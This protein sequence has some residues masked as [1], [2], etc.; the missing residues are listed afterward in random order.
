MSR[1]ALSL[2]L[3]LTVSLG[4]LAV[5]ALVVADPRELAARIASLDAAAFVGA[6]ALTA[7][8]R[9]LMAFKWR[10]LLL[11]RHVRIPL[12]TAVRAYF[13]SS[14]AGLFLPVTLGA[15]AARVAAT[16]QFGIA[17]VTAS[18]VVERTVGAA[19]V[20]LVAIGGCALIAGRL[21]A[22]PLASLLWPLG[23]AGVVVAIA[24][25]VSLWLSSRWAAQG[26]D[27]G[28]WLRR[29]AGAYGAYAAHPAT[30]TVF[31]LLSIVES[32]VPA[33]T[34]FVVARGLGIQA[35]AWLFLAAV[36][37]A[38]MV[39][40]LPVSLGGFGVQEAA[41][42]YLAGSLGLAAED[43]IATML[44]CDAILLLILLP[45]AFDVSILGQHRQARASEPGEA[46]R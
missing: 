8:D 32:L 41:F 3:R 1:R 2:A 38:L 45:A 43:A 5:L 9:V 46:G 16:R 22:V 12:T 35:P 28:T 6:I 27:R 7:G 24:F 34:A 29:V 23:I 42:V 21:A 39:A 11:A 20:I 31:F 30:L 25:P 4:L 44:V 17:A 26:A 19:A 15:D 18:I 13:A 37:I 33:L 10:L 14:F 36:P 40:R